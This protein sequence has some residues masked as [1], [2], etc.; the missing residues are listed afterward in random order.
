MEQARVEHVRLDDIVPGNNPRRYFDPQEMT[1]LTESVRS[2][3]VLQPVLVRPRA[4]GGFEL[5]AGERRF[6]AATSVGLS[7]I[8]AMIREV[9]D[10]EAEEMGL[11]ENTIR[12]DMSPTEEARSAA[13]LLELYGGNRDEVLAR[14]GG[15]TP[16]KLDRRLALRNC[17]EEVCTAL[18][19]RKIL[20]GHAELLAAVP[21]DKQNNTLDKI[22]THNLPVGYVKE[23]L[24]KIAQKLTAAT[25][26]T[27]GCLTCSFNS[28][29]QS[30]L[31]SQALDNGHC[32]NGKCFEEKNHAHVERLRE[33]LTKEYPMVVVIETG[34]SDTGVRVLPDGPLGVGSEQAVVCRG[35]GKFGATVSALP[36]HIGETEREVCFDPSCHQSKVA[37]QI[38][39]GGEKKKG[40]GKAETAGNSKSKASVKG[41]GSKTAASHISSRVEEYRVKVWRK[42][43]E[44]EASASREGSLSLL[45]ALSLLHRTGKIDLPAKNELGMDMDT[46]SLAV[47]ARA[48]QAVPGEKRDQ[49]IQVLI[50]SSMRN[51]EKSDLVSAMEYLEVDLG[52][53]WKVDKEYLSLLTKS[54]IEAVATE[55]GLKEQMGESFTAAMGKKKEESI[56][57]L[58]SAQGFDF[59]GKIPG[60]MRYEA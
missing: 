23:A 11:I 3:G 22:L 54:E 44:A 43:A 53:Y 12:A 38:K 36:G 56:D 2:K 52:K 41:S 24:A 28:S 14:L 17:T 40:N 20:L 5:I 4:G 47:L 34:S 16:S 15:W 18:D 46:T 60:V 27:E 32:T 13:R 59:N 10:L 7:V 45:I 35:C 6:R 48:A 58:L 29:R 51:L 21:K 49:A 25:F 55:I 19:E 26:D 50:G 39:I 9:S 37:E 8:P 33:E 57:L 30:V 42:I 1:E 31:F